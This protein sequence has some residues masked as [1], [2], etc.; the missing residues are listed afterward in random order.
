MYEKFYNELN[1]LDSAFC[2]RKISSF[3]KQDKHIIIDGKKYLNLSSNDYLGLAENKDLVNEFL[4]Q[5]PYSFGS[6]SSRLLTGSS[7]IY[8]EL[9]SYLADIYE[10]DKALLFNSGY[11]A[12]VGIVSSLADKGDVIFSDKLNHASIIDGMKLSG[13]DYYR[14]KHLDYEHLESLLQK[15][16][17]NHQTALI[18]SESIFSMDG[19]SADLNKLVELKKKYNAI[20]IIDEAH[21][22]GVYGDRALGL[23]EVQDCISDI[24]LVIAT[25]GKAIASVGAFCCG[26]GVLIDYLINKARS[27]IFSTALPEASVAFS[28]FMLKNVLPTTNNLRNHL[29][30]TSNRLKESISETGLKVLGDFHI[31]PIIIGENDK[32]VRVSNFLRDR[33]YYVLP[34]RHP[35]VAKGSARIRLSMRADICLDEVKEIPA[36]LKLAVSGL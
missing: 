11:H 36:L 34:I 26:K 4:K 33:N 18:I 1:E 23:C 24:D 7:P 27:F 2:N 19:D 13:A 17:N 28:L 16:R 32:T 3:I 22:F 29:L 5:G 8:N 12:N 21:A 14:Y 10:K 20:L 35:T 6:A 30:A 31:I 15:H 25:F 9:E